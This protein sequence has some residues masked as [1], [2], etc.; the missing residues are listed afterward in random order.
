MSEFSILFVFAISQYYDKTEKPQMGTI[1]TP[2][3][4]S[5][6]NWHERSSFTTYI[7]SLIHWSLGAFGFISLQDMLMAGIIM[8]VWT[9][10]C[11]NH[12]L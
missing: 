5:E 4:I 8:E 11:L 6:Q 3:C 1:L 7:K 12:K 2:A 10:D 9:N